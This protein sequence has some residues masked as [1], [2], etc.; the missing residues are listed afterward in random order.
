MRLT[1]DGYRLKIKSYVNA[2]FYALQRFNGRVIRPRANMIELCGFGFAPAIAHLTSVMNGETTFSPRFHRFP[3][4]REFYAWFL[5]E[6]VYMQ[7]TEF[8]KQGVTEHEK[9]IYLSQAFFCR[10]PFGKHAYLQEC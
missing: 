9:K 10:S 5:T 1:T 2:C 7:T 6:V 4:N 3:S 8:G